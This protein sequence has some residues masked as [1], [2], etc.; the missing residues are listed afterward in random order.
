MSFFLRHFFRGLVVLV[1]AA[2][3]VWVFYA[4][5]RR[6]DGLVPLGVPGLG[7]LATVAL[8]TVIGFLA[9]SFVTRR[10]FQLVEGLFSRL[11]LVR[12]L[13]GSL[14]DL[15]GAFV[16]EKRS[17]DRPV[18][19]T[20]GTGFHGK[21]LG[22]VTRDSLE[23]FG[24]PGYVAVYLPQSYNFAGSTLLF[25]KDQVTPVAAPATEVMAFVLSGGVARG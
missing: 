22:F 7:V 3:T 4:V 15:V 24:L 19:V 17:F 6:I 16:G 20:L 18:V 12:L 13:Y 9:S 23:S 5:F 8:V 10:V 11:P 1:P 2:A 14:R 25:P 21:A